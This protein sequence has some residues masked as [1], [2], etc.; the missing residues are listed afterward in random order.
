MYTRKTPVQLDCSVYFARE[1]LYGKWKVGLIHYISHGVQ[2]PGELQ[3]KLRGSNRKV[4]NVQLNELE[5]AG[6]ITKKV[7]PQLPP[8]VEY[9]LTEIGATLLPVIRAMGE[10]GDAYRE[11]LGKIP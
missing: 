5:A 9:T 11:R 7:Y 10:W 3:R 2:R 1:I 8:K 6:I 4:L